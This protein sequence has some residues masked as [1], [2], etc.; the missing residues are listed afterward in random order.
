M[1][2]I[3]RPL[4][5]IAVATLSSA[6]STALATPAQPGV[7]GQ[8]AV[9]RITSPDAHLEAT[10]TVAD[11]V[12]YALALDGK[13]LVLPSPVSLTLGRRPRARPR[14]PA[15]PRGAAR[16][17][18]GDPD[19]AR[20]A[21]RGEE[22]LPRAG[23]RALGR[24]DAARARLRRRLRAALGD[25]AA[26][27]ASACATRASRSPSRRSRRR[28]SSAATGAHH[29]YEGLWRHEPISALGLGR[30]PDG[31]AAARRSTCRGGPK[32]AL[33]QADLDDY[34]AM[35]LG[36]RPSHPRQLSSVFPRRA[37]EEQPGG[38]PGLR[39]RAHRA[40]RRHRRDRGHAQLPVA[41]ASW[42]RAAT[43]TSSRATW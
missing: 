12:R 19:T 32:L 36:Y 18:R 39:P 24:R 38:Y 15:R 4:A 31:L 28:S 35:Y 43:P 29:G 3:S 25:G 26:R 37:L 17:R 42:S 2:N 33:L 7:P 16:G 8:A 9:Q 27:A 11:D 30:T 34:P 5:A 14:R 22:R 20:Q 41:R 10:I 23:A 13:P 6:G 1:R 21:G 40:R